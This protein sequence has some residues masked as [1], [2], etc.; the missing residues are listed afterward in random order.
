M[1]NFNFDQP[2]ADTVL[3]SAYAVLQESGY[4]GPVVIDVPDTDAHVAA[5]VISRQLPCI[6]CIKSIQGK[7]QEMVFRRNLV[8][9]EM[10]DCIV[11]RHCMTGCDANLGGYGKGKKSVYDQMAKSPVVCRQFSRCWDS[12]DLK[13]GVAEELITFTRHV[14]CGDKSSTMAEAR[15]VEGNWKERGRRWTRRH[16]S[17]SLQMQRVYATTASTPTTWLS[18]TPH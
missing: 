7:K 10:S 3:F 5:V 9:D 11:Q 15:A 14:I 8:T 12:L 13:E 16:S 1:Q 6:L 18:G 17:V 2:R 4:S